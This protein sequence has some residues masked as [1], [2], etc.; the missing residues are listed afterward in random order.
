[1]NFH[2]MHSVFQLVKPHPPNGWYYLFS[3]PNIQTLYEVDLP[4][5]DQEQCEENYS[6]EPVTDNMVCAGYPWGGKDA[7]TVSGQNRQM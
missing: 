2:F 1:M 7:C 3:A 4:L 6:P 5:Y